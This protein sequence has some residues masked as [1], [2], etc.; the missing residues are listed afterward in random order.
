MTFTIYLVVLKK[1]REGNKKA[2]KLNRKNIEIQF[3]L[4]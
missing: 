3:M 1:F 2:C 4:G